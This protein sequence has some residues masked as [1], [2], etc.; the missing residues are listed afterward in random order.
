M[1]SSIGRVRRFHPQR[2]TR[3]QDQS[4]VGQ[5]PNDPHPSLVPGGCATRRPVVQLKSGISSSHPRRCSQSVGEGRRASGI[6]SYCLGGSL[7]GKPR[8]LTTAGALCSPPSR[9]PSSCSSG[10]PCRLSLLSIAPFPGQE[11]DLSPDTLPCPSAITTSL[12][13]TARPLLGSNLAQLTLEP[14]AVPAPGRSAPRS[15][16]A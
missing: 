13:P 6:R 12:S 7:N 15:L 14:S 3:S 2:Q 9:P 10:A 8:R 1:V 4:L 5:T 16:P 11:Q